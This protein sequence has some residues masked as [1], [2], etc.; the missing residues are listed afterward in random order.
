MATATNSGAAHFK[1]LCKRCHDSAKRFVET[2]GYRPD[3][4]LDG[5]PLDPR[6][7]VYARGQ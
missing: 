5:W 3:V 2:R 1:S 6:H 4:G 7:P